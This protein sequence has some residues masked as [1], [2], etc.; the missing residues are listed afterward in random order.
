MLPQ[1]IE[2]SSH[3]E[4]RKSSGL[5]QRYPPDFVQLEGEKQFGLRLRH[6][7]R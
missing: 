2:K 4:S 5:S 1:Y 3:G 7:Q 6:R